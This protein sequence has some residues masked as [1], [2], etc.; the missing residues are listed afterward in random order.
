VEHSADE[1]LRMISECNFPATSGDA[2]S[3][4]FNCWMEHALDTA[5]EFP[6]RLCGW[7]IARL[8]C[9]KHPAL[10]K[11]QVRLQWPF[12]LVY[13]CFV[14]NMFATPCTKTTTLY[15]GALYDSAPQESR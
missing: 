6:L 15:F 5:G 2:L 1:Q 8:L 7:A 9:S 10:E 4:F 12:V 11:I 13:A 14:L 3:L